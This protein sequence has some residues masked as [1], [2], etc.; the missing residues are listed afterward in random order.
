M[1]QNMSYCRF[2]NTLEALDECYEALGRDDLHLS[3][4]EKQAAAEL[5]KLCR[6]IADDFE[7][8]D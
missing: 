1:P 4:G 6:N 7:T 2:S 5:I 8:E 3:D